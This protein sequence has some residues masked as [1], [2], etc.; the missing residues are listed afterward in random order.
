MTY[1]AWRYRDEFTDFMRLH[2]TINGLS[3]K[4]LGEKL[5]RSQSAVQQW[6]QGRSSPNLINIKK[7]SEVFNVP[8]IEIIELLIKRLK[9][10]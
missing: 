9:D 5:G 4:M 3:T 10:V 7:L 6:E 1:K 8:I 2:R